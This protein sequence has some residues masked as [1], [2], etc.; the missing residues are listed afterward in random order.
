ME[1]LGPNETMEIE[2]EELSVLP[3]RKII[4]HLPIRVRRG[5][6][7]YES[8]LSREVLGMLLEATGAR[9]STVKKFEGKSR[10]K[11]TE[12]KHDLLRERYSLWQKTWRIFGRNQDPN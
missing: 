6:R 7:K 4:S 8:D 2:E 12:E 10:E 1:E 9:I 5:L 11:T 3:A